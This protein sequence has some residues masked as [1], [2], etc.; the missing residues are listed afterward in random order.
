M[1]IK[2]G[3]PLEF[4]DLALVKIK[5]FQHIIRSY[6]QNNELKE[7]KESLTTDIAM[8]LTNLLKIHDEYTKD[9][10]EQVASMALRIGEIMGLDDT[11]L[12]DLYYAS[13]LHDIGKVIIPNEILNKKDQLT[14]EEF[15]QIKQH[16]EI[17]FEATKDLKNLSSISK[18]I[19]HHHERFDGFGYP[20]QLKEED[21]PLL[22]RIITVVDAYDAMTSERPYRQALSK[23][24]AVGE[25]VKHKN[26]QFDAEIVDLLIQLINYKK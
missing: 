5:A 8:S 25:L 10:S 6:Y 18:Y 24:E 12:Q 19:R 16:P 14:L 22:S 26:S 11:Q 1:D 15:N 9:H 13:L 17:G 20:D 4:S 23:S 2:K 21:I 7:L 3:S